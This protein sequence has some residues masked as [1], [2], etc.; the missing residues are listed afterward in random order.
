MTIWIGIIEI[1]Q[2]LSLVVQHYTEMK[3]FILVVSVLTQDRLLFRKMMVE[4]Y[5]F[6]GK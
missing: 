2:G 6:I 3:C 1:W 5:Y 4:L